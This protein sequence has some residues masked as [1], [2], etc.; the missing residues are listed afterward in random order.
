AAADRSEDAH[1][2][3]IVYAPVHYGAE[4][5]R[6]VTTILANIAISTAGENA[7][8]AFFVLPQEANVWGMRDTGGSPDLLP[9]YRRAA[10]TAAHEDMERHWGVP[11]PHGDGLT[12]EGMMG[13]GK[14]RALVVMN[15]NPLMLA[16]AL[17]R[18]EEHTSELQSHLNL[19]CRL[20]L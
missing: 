15:D 16:S 9:G 1:P 17:S 2:M 11:L 6:E 10:D 14:L 3:S 7:P 8:E 19:V 13:D 20:L 5:A 12:F 4:H 18:S